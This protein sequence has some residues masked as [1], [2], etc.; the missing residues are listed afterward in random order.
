MHMVARRTRLQ[1]VQEIAALG[2]MLSIGLA[3][4]GVVLVALPALLGLLCDAV[5][6]EQAPLQDRA[7]GSN[8]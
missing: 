1:P 5:R 2:L 7:G 8:L 6:P 4:P 3:Q